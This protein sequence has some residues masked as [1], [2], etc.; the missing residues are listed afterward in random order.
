M[1]ETKLQ[2]ESMDKESVEKKES[3]KGY[4]FAEVPTGFAKVIALEGK[5][6]DTDSLLLA[7][8]N[9]LRDNLGFKLD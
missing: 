6:I 4:Y 8:A 9:C 5:V 7:M 2:E 3:V 1:E